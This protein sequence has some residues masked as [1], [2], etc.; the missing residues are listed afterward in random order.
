MGVQVKVR[1]TGLNIKK[2][3]LV[4]QLAKENVHSKVENN[5]MS[6]K[7]ASESLENKAVIGP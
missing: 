3:K 4:G 7:T 2:K 5:V 6:L 1:V